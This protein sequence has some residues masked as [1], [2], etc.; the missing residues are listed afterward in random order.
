MDIFVPPHHFQCFPS[1]FNSYTFYFHNK[2][3]LSI[4]HSPFSSPSPSQDSPPPSPIT[5]FMSI[6]ILPIRLID[7]NDK[8]RGDMLFSNLL[9]SVGHTQDAGGAGDR[10]VEACCAIDLGWSGDGVAQ[11]VLQPAGSGFG[12]NGGQGG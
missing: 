5:S 12:E 9:E 4:F 8:F 3:L 2:I 10:V 7:F 11:P 6:S 1:F